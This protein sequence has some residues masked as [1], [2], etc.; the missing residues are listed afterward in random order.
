MVITKRRRSTLTILLVIFL[1]LACGQQTNAERG[2]EP[3]K[4]VKDHVE[5]ICSYGKRRCVTGRAIGQHTKEVLNA[6]YAKQMQSGKVGLRVI[7]IVKRADE[8]TALPVLVVVWIVA[9]GAGRI[10]KWY[11]RV[12]TVGQWFSIVV[13]V[14]LVIIGVCQTYQMYL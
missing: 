4:Q 5:V 14:V 1:M 7:D 11:G 8:A 12:K 13:G 10:G 3:K 6:R 9:C 2:G